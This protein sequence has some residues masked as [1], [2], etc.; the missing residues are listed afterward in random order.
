[1]IEAGGQEEKHKMPETILEEI[2]EEILETQ[3]SYKAQTV[4][5]VDLLKE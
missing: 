3:K 2:K 1:M 4:S 5:D